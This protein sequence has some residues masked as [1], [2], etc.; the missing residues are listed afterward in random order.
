MD[1][2]NKGGLRL[3]GDYGLKINNIKA[4]S[5]YGYNKGIRNHYD[6]NK[7]MFHNSLFSDFIKANGMKYKKNKTLDIICLEFDYGMCSYE[8]ELKKLNRLLSEAETDEQKQFYQG[9]IDTVIENEELYSKVDKDEIRK[10][11]YENGVTVTYKDYNPDGTVKK[12]KTVDYKML[13]RNASKAKMGQVM[14]INKK[15]YKKAYDWLTMGLGKKLPKTNAKIVEISA[16]APLTTSTIVGK[17]KIPVEDVLILND[18]DSFFTTVAKVVKTEDYKDGKKKC[19][20]VDEEYEVKN[21]LWDGM[22][23][24]ETTLLPS[25]VNGMVL[26]RNHFFKMCGFRTKIQ[27]FF[28]DWCKDKGVD[29]NTYEVEDMF[30][31]KHKLKDIKVITTNNA[32]KWLKFKDLMGNTDVEAYDYWKQRVNNDGSYFGIVKTDHESKLGKYQQMSYQM[33]NTLPCEKEDV[34]EIVK[35]SVEYVEEIKNDAEAF[36]RFLRKNANAVNQYSMMADLYR[37]NP[38]IADTR[39]FRK[40]KVSI[41]A[42]YVK[43][44]RKG[45]IMVKADNLTTCGNLYELLLYAVGEDYLRGS[46]FRETKS[47]EYIGCYNSMFEDGERLAGFRSPH[48]SPNNIMYFRN[49]H[50][51]VYDEYFELSK[52]ILVVDNIE[53]DL[54]SRSN[55]SDHDLKKYWIG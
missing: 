2:R 45:K 55:G 14:F 34:A 11:F 22:G 39:W 41:I 33:I 24:V 36:Y 9:L 49:V 37:W 48:N 47:R 10:D 50:N 17:V 40:E 21:T 26:L 8:D 13:Y 3:T 27:K 42:K 12:E 29:Y 38:D 25:E 7:A 51:K 43:H 35:P 23:L 6:Y 52:N 15:L 1:V 46:P 4:G 19:A 44:L 31:V 32:I 30:G 16:Y 18:Q 53:T 20:V 28:K 54:Q 5:L